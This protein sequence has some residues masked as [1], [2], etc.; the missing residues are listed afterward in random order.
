MIQHHRNESTHIKEPNMSQ[1]TVFIL[2]TFT[3][4]QNSTAFAAMRSGKLNSA[5]YEKIVRL[6]IL[7]TLSN[8]NI[9]VTFQNLL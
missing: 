4:R 6:P 1:S 7:K 3:R 2:F 9:F 8:R 5:Y